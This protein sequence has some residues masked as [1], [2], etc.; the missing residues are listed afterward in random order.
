MEGYIEFENW[1]RR[2]EKEE[3]ENAMDLTCFLL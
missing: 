1:H 2:K 3:R